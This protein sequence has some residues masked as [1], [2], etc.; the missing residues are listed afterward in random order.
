MVLY[1]AAGLAAGCG[2]GVSSSDPDATVRPDGAPKLPQGPHHP[3]VI[4]SIT[5]PTTNAEAQQIGLDVDGDGE[6]D[7]Q[8]GGIV[9]LLSANGADINATVAEQIDRGDLT[10]LADLQATALDSAENS[11]LYVWKG[12]NP[13]PA[14][15]LDVNDTVC[16]Q[17]LMGTGGFDVTS[18]DPADAMIFGAITAS[19]YSGDRGVIILEVPLFISD[20]AL[21]LQMIDARA[22]VE[23][24]ESGLTE[25]K[26]AGAV[27][28]RYIQE[29]VIPQLQVVL[30]VVINEDCTGTAP[31]C[32]IVDSNG[33]VAV[34]LFDTDDSCTVSLEELQDSVLLDSLLAP[35]L[36]L[37]DEEGLSGRDGVVDSVALGVVFTAVPASYTIPQGLP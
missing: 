4:D 34:G 12:D 6:V 37:Q 27:T 5:L 14:P 25:G 22:E 7:N 18:A 10:H 31:N 1:L 35:T 30:G 19:H 16:R 26:L 15:C 24:A 17:H 33:D 21:T 32:C 28:D 11:A 36:D 13:S 20:S 2:P 3:Y 29:T 23:V 8:L 9:A